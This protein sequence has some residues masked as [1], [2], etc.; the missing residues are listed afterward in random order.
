[1]EKEQGIRDFN[2]SIV[3]A[4][5][6]GVDVRILSANPR[7]RIRF[8]RDG[9]SVSAPITR[10]RLHT[11]ILVIDQSVVFLGSHNFTASAFTLNIETSCKIE[12]SEIGKYFYQYFDLLWKI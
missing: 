10:R 4:R 8:S 9:C 7:I 12:S 3:T 5:K 2:D 1:M 11:K 6:R